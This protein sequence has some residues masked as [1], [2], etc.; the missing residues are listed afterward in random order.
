MNKY[1]ILGNDSIE[2]VGWALEVIV[3]LQNF[4]TRE[5][6]INEIESH[7]DRNHRVFITHEEDVIRDEVSLIFECKTNEEFIKTTNILR[8]LT[9]NKSI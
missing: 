3:K 6:D 9:E 1:Y 7:F 4:R 5:H 8:K 2:L